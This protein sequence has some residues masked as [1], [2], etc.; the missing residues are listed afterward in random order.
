[1]HSSGNSLAAVLTAESLWQFSLRFYPGVK[2][3]CLNMQDTLGV[4]INLLMLLCLLEQRKLAISPAQLFQLHQRLTD[5][6]SVFTQ[7]LRQLRKHALQAALLPEQQ[8]QLKQTLLHAELQLEQ[9]E[10]QLLLQHCP[11][12]YSAAA[13][14]LEHYLSLLC[15]DSYD[16]AHIVDL[17][18]ALAACPL[19]SD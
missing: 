13:G 4:N 10:Q 9:L 15:H 7:P 6:S 16:P 19:S 5:F 17:R 3:L 14:L 12:P 8:Q 18:Q 2:P 11:M 1:M